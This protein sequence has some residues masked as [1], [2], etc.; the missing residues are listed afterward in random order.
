M[1]FTPMSTSVQ[2]SLDSTQSVPVFILAGGMGTRISE[3]TQFKPKPMIEIG[4]IPI[5]L[6][7]MRWYYSFGFNDFVVCAGY[8]NWEIKE[9]FLNYEFRCNHLRLDHRVATDSHPVALGKNSEQEN[10][11]VSIVDTGLETLTGARL[12]RALDEFQSAQKFNHF[13]LTYGDGL[14][15]VDLKGEFDFHL[16]HGKIGTVVG[17]PPQSR[18]GELDVTRQGSVAGFV[19]KPES[20]TGLINGGFFFFRKDFRTYLESDSECILERAPLTNLAADGELMLYKHK[21]FW[22]CM[23]T[24]RD[25]NYLQE[26]WD[27]GNAPWKVPTQNPPRS[28]SA[29]DKKDG[30]EF[31]GTT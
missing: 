7:I 5:L 16:N 24:L 27:R 30:T 6:H 1:N 17:V 25:R 15:D 8:R 3:E 12:A 20:K 9:Y 22:Q 10:W 21:G 31:V 18:F 13:A 23:D 2:T 29:A 14:C 11:R 26:I 4:E 19:E 28:G